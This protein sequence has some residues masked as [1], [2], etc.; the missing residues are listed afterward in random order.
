M[1]MC[2]CMFVCVYICMHA[3]KVAS[4]VSDSL[5]PFVAHQAPLWGSLCE[6]TRVG[7]HA[8][9]QEDLPHPGITPASLT[10]PVFVGMF[11]TTQEAPV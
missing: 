5:Q 2:V 3:C 10:S 9:L 11:F 4:I 8:L 6:N 1:C 7:S